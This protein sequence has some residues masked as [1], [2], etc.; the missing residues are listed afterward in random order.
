MLSLVQAYN[1]VPLPAVLMHM[2]PCLPMP[3]P[4]PVQVMSTSMA[5]GSP[6]VK[7]RATGGCGRERVC[8]RRCR[9]GAGWR[10]LP[11]LPVAVVADWKPLLAALQL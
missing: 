7:L 6:E 2:P 4:M 3:C 11:L 10:L 9:L 8:G 1:K 5:S